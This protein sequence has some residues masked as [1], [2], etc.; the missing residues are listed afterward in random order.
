MN[1]LGIL[2]K[3]RFWFGKSG[4]G[5]EILY[6]QQIPSDAD[7]SMATLSSKDLEL[8]KINKIKLLEFNSEFLNF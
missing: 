4:V 2:L 1:H 3:G 7:G 8:K 5:P 6:F